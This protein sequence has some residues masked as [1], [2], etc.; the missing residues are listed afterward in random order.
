MNNNIP[1]IEYIN[2]ETNPT[3]KSDYSPYEL[4]FYQDKN[5]LLDIESY[6]KFLDNAISRFRKSIF[7]KH[8]K[9]YLIGLGLDRC[10]VQSNI[11]TEMAEIEMH[12]A[13][14]IFDIALIICEH[15]LNTTGK[16]T[17]FDLVQ[18]LKEEHRS[19]RIPLI[20]LTKTSHQLL[21]NS[22]EFF[23]HPDQWFGNWTSL[24]EKYYSGITQDIAFKIIFNLDRALEIGSSDDASLLTLREKIIDWSVYNI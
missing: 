10:M 6:K 21:H 3:I 12:H 17:T 24:L 2:I 19:N 13:I 4:P 15:V 20:F 7:Y 23:V 1:G 9:G 22:Q 11:T 18:L 16:I 5:S 8:Y 14:T